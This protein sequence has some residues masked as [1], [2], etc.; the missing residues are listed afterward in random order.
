MPKPRATKLETATARR[1]LT[2]RKKPYWT[3][4]SPN[5]ALGYRRNRAA[6]TWSVRGTD[7]HGS[8]WIKRL[9]LADDFEK[10][11]GRTVLTYWEAIDVARATA[12]GT[13]DHG[14]RPVTIA[15][16]LDIYE[17]D[18]R[19]RGGNP[20]NVAHVRGHV[21]PGLASRLVSALTATE[22][23]KWRDGLLA[24]G[25][26]ASSVNRTRTP[27]RAA[28]NLAAAHDE[29]IA[30]ARAWRIG[31]AGL[32][33]AHRA[34]DM[35][36]S[37]AE[38]LRLITCA[39]DVDHRFGLYVEVLA[40]TGARGSQASRLVVSDLQADRLMMP[41][42]AKGRGRKIIKRYPVPIPPGLAAALAVE[43]RG[44]AGGMPLLLQSSGTHWGVGR[45]NLRQLFRAAVTAA[46]LDSDR[47]TPY[48][49]RHSSIVRQLQRNVPI[50]LVASLHDTSVAIIEANYSAHIAHHADE[51]VRGALLDA[52]QP[53]AANV[54]TLPGERL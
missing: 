43:C 51:L 19:A 38:V 20:A 8:D 6:G 36:L 32:P 2:V 17:A 46:G 35:S 54:V 42:S 22:L 4:I 24:K 16:A 52:A 15:E 7:G 23:R 33:D 41:T 47:V 29:R 45:S 21:S 37:D 31:L 49:L 12:R 34:R 39:R 5:I 18:L 40:I 14:G 53:A 48:A 44:R 13:S 11:D 26:T 9:G 27:L 3:T 30:N 50:R 1:R 25:L 28:L 10:S